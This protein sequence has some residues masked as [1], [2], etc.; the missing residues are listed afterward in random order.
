MIEIICNKKISIKY[1]FYLWDISNQLCSCKKK[2][3]FFLC[4]NCNN[5]LQLSA[6]CSKIHVCNSSNYKTEF[7]LHRPEILF[8]KY[9]KI[10]SLIHKFPPSLKS[11]IFF[12]LV[13]VRS[14]GNSVQFS[15]SV[16][17]DSL[18]PHELQHAR[19]P[20]PSPTPGVHSNSHPSSW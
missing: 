6:C 4:V 8:Q 12:P 9:P 13:Q 2:C 3:Q 11:H 17:F 14:I 15:R 10:H 7:C 1:Q 5:A 18:R 20:C 16:M 19:P